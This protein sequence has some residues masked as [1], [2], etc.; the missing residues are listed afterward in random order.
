MRREVDEKGGGAGGAAAA[1]AAARFSAP[2]TS[3]LRLIFSIVETRRPRLGTLSLCVR[4]VVVVVKSDQE[5]ERGGAR[6]RNGDDDETWSLTLVFQ[7]LGTCGAKLLVLPIAFSNSLMKNS[8]Q[9]VCTYVWESIDR[10]EC[11]EESQSLEIKKTE[12]ENAPRIQAQS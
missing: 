11:G 2:L 1:A 7:A 10:K 9:P 3:A 12:Y 4:V 5:G 6:R 8:I